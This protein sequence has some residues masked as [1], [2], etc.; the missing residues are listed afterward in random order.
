MVRPEGSTSLNCGNGGWPAKRRRTTRSLVKETRQVE[1]NELTEAGAH[2]F[3]F[4]TALVT[5]CL[6][7]APIDWR[8]R[9]GCWREC[10]ADENGRRDSSR[11]LLSPTVFPTARDVRHCLSQH[12]GKDGAG[13]RLA[14]KRSF[15][16]LSPQLPLSGKD[17]GG[18]GKPKTREYTVGV[19]G[20]TSG[21]KTVVK[22]RSL[23]THFTSS[24]DR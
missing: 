23:R 21:Y 13:R 9:A 16:R 22:R 15:S 14:R 20:N 17:R 18:V 5:V 7:G 6:S 24:Q 3:G 8:P 12:S 2:S 10:G 19:H 4:S 1:K 11:R